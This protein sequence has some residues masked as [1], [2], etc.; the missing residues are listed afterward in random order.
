MRRHS[1]S[2]FTTSGPAGFAG[3]AG[4][5]FAAT[6]GFANTSTG[7]TTGGVVMAN[8]TAS[9][10]A[11]MTAGAQPGI[12]YKRLGKVIASNSKGTFSPTIMAADPRTGMREAIYEGRKAGTLG[13]SG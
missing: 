13:L 5:G 2:V 9:Q 11:H 6:P 4:A 10:P 1:S 8:R 3:G 7:F 12:N